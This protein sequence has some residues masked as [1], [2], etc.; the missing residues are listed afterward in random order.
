MYKAKHNLLPNYLQNIM[1][2]EVGNINEYNLRNFDNFVPPKTK[3]N[4]F[5]KSYIPS[6]TK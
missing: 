2:E 5:L 3:K 6:A 4:Y 1:P